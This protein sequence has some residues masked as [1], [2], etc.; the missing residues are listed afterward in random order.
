MH[1]L[2]TAVVST[3]TGT[4]G[5]PH[6]TGFT[7]LDRLRNMLGAYMTACV[8]LVWRREMA[9]VLEEKS[10]GL[11]EALAGFLEAERSR[12]RAFETAEVMVLPPD[13]NVFARHPA[14]AG[15]RGAPDFEFTVKAG[16]EDVDGK[17]TRG[18]VEGESTYGGCE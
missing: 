10:S 2:E 15:E 8:E 9:E 4:A 11:T 12:R 14:A 17:M 18:D 3:R 6:Q 16:S 1:D 7:H 13:V 5:K